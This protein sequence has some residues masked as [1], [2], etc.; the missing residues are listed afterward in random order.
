MDNILKQPTVAELQELFTEDWVN[1]HS[2][3]SYGC[4]F[5]CQDTTG[6]SI[7]ISNYEPRYGIRMLAVAMK[8]EM[9]N[10]R[11]EYP[12]FPFEEHYLAMYNLLSV[13]FAKENEL[14]SHSLTEK[15]SDS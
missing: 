1:K 13:M 12:E 2:D 10:L 11:N 6:A 4:F 15:T 7:N 5:V 3:M 9:D 8:T 14:N